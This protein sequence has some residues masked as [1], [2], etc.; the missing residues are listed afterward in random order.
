MVK[1]DVALPATGGVAAEV[2]AII[3]NIR[4]STGSNITTDVA[5]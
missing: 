3:I 2:T 4:T 5:L 1:E